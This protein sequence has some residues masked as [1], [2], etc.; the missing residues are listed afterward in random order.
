MTMFDAQ[1]KVA[2][3]AGKYPPFQFRGVDGVEHELPNPLTLKERH[4]TL[5]GAGRVKDVIREINPA[6]ADAIDDMP[7]FVSAALAEAWLAQGGEPGKSES[8]FSA[9]TNGAEPSKPTSLSEAS[10]STG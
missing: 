8:E 7:I 3:A 5:I 2:E 6:V 4:G 1:A 10:T 9:Q